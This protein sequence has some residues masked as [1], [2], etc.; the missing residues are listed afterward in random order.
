MTMRAKNKTAADVKGIAK[1]PKGRR[2]TI[3]DM[4]P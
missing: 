1:V 4:R 2:L 3:D